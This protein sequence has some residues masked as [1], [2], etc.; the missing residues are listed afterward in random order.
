[1]ILVTDFAK[2]H[3]K[4]DFGGTKISS[5]TPEEFQKVL[6]VFPPLREEP[7]YA[8]FCKHYY[9]RNFTDARLAVCEITPERAGLLKSGYSSRTPQELPVLSRWFESQDIL[10]EKA[11]LL[12]II[13]YSRE[14]LLLEGDVLEEGVLWGVVSINAVEDC[15]EKPMPPATMVRNA[16][17]ISEGGSGVPLDREAYLKSVDYWSKFA[18]I[19]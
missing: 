1:M 16:L 6:E 14:Q 3:F 5:H 7:G 15:E 12:D 4:S 8:P 13:L 11:P 10:P 18:L 19:K 9:V 2:R 17:G